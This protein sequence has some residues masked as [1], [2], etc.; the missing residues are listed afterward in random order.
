MKFNLNKKLILTAI[1]IAFAF[2][3]VAFAETPADAK[4]QYNMGVDFY[5]VGKYDQAMGSFRRAID[6]DPNYTDAY[7]NLGSI[8][9]FLGQYD[10][11]LT[12]FKQVI[13]RNPD[14]YGSVYKAASL[15]AKLG[16]GEK[17]KTY[18]SL[19]PNNTT[20]Y[21]KAQELAAQLGTTMPEVNYENSQIT[22]MESSPQT[23]NSNQVFD[24]IISPTGITSDR[25]GNIYVAGFS[26]NS[27]IKITPS[28]ERIIFLKDSRL[29]GPIGMVTD[30]EG[31]IYI[32]NYNADNILKVSSTG[33]VSILVGNIQKPYGLYVQGNFLYI[34]SQ[35]LNAVIKYK[36]Y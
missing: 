4:L 33:M 15:S 20:T 32:A 24:N 28:G 19:I 29:N 11:A 17:A 25:L 16:Q 2:P 36:L 8:L 22:S 34:S 31:N 1:L 21:R 6:L 7:Y 13:V 14:D 18:L 3:G 35:G 27:V 5:K 26:D 10:A 30:N 12:V 9:E 23:N